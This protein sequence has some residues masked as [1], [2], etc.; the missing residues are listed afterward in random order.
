[1]IKP[2]QLRLGNY[3]YS[4]YHGKRMQVE[5]ISHKFLVLNDAMQLRV[6]LHDYEFEEIPLTPEILEEFGFV[7][8]NKVSFIFR[9]HTK[10]DD[11]ECLFLQRTE[12]GN[13]AEWLITY[14]CNSKTADLKCT[15]KYLHELQNIYYHLTGEELEMKSRLSAASTFQ[16]AV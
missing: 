4:P 7:C 3:I 2:I 13:D 6:W 14:T 5:E 10:E 8:I 15:V 11:N 1:M 9:E 12:A 16:I